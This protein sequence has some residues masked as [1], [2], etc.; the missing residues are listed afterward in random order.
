MQHAQEM[1]SK[2]DNLVE[3]ES[4][5][6]DRAQTY[7]VNDAIADV[8]NRQRLDFMPWVRTLFVVIDA[9]FCVWECLTFESFSFMSKKVNIVMNKIY[10]LGEPAGD[11]ITERS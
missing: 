9:C 3:T 11:Q 5:R 6:Q 1:S 4:M 2:G 7:S 8:V 10:N